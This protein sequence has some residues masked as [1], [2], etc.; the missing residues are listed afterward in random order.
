MM[1]LYLLDNPV[2]LLGIFLVIGYVLSMA[3]HRIGIPHIIVYLT[4]GLILSNF[5]LEELNLQTELHIWFQ[6]SEIVAL[7]LIGFKI[8]TEIKISDIRNEPKFI[9]IVTLA[10][11]GFAFLFVFMLIFL[12]V[13]NLILALILGGLATA[14]APAATIEVF[15]KL[16][17]KGP[18]SKRI[19]WLLALDDWFAVVIV[20]GILA[21]LITIIG[22]EVDF[23][24]FLTSLWYELGISLI[25]GLIM[26]VLL[27]FVIERLHDNLEMM[28]L[29]LSVLIL[30]IGF[31][32]YVG[33]SVIIATMT[34]GFV[35]TN[36]GGANYKKSG[37]LLEIIMSPVLMIFFTF[38]GAEIHLA[39]I[40][41]TTIILAAIYLI[42]RSIGKIA[43]AYTGSTIVK[44][45][46]KI[47]SNLGMGLLAQGGVSLGL[48]SI[49]EEI[50]HGTEYEEVGYTVVTLVVV[51]TF[52]SVLIGSV[53]AK[54]AAKRAGEVGMAENSVY[55]SK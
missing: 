14:T 29:T 42:G 21:F 9:L 18:L 41:L 1:V 17:V 53:G 8:G 54:F 30:V 2:Y 47:R 25:V 20:E 15:R 44:M 55:N 11:T 23:L 26:G 10:E 45:P 35:A 38:V 50:L 19:K 7:G 46:S 5:V 34:I 51:S 33:T 6:T 36:I 13:H 3:L 40:K 49:V 16:R 27:D 28:E 4:S 43:G 31:C 22:E 24:H 12:F 32:F 39:S 52:F 37:D 48:A